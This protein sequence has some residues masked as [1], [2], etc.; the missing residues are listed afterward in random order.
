MQEF[1]RYCRDIQPED[2]LDLSAYFVGVAC[3]QPNMEKLLQAYLYF[4]LNKY[5]SGYHQVLLYERSVA[6][7]DNGRS[8]VDFTFLNGENRILLVGTNFVDTGVPGNASG[9][10]GA[11]ETMEVRDQITAA[12]DFLIEQYDISGEDIIMAHFT[13]DPDSGPSHDSNIDS[14]SI[15]IDDLMNWRKEFRKRL[16]DGRG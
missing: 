6:G 8:S 11:C 9:S 13:T 12:R 16:R 1:I 15:S 5:Y 4:N 2:D 3:L 14:H 10:D 7:K